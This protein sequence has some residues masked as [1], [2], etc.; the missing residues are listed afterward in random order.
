MVEGKGRKASLQGTQ[1]IQN[2][3]ITILTQHR[4]QADIRSH[5]PCQTHRRWPSATK[6]H[7]WSHQKVKAWPSFQLRSESY[8]TAICLLKSQLLESLL[9]VKILSHHSKSSPLIL[10]TKRSLTL[11][12]TQPQQNKLKTLHQIGM[13]I[14]CWNNSTRSHS[15]TSHTTQEWTLKMLIGKRRSLNATDR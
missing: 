11:G 7:I 3:T 4:E 12:S 8:Q 2:R 1:R 13:T 15:E 5:C 14:R 10:S 9:N 6:S